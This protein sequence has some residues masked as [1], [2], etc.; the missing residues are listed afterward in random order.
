MNH[1]VRILIAMLLS[2]VFIQQPAVGQ[3]WSAGISAAAGAAAEYY[4]QE[5]ET[6]RLLELERK[7]AA[8]WEAQELRR[9][10]RDEAMRRQAAAE[11]AARAQEEVRRQQQIAEEKRQ[12]EAEQKR[13]AVSTGTGFFV[14][15]GGYLVTN[16]HVID[17]STDY[18]IRDH[19]GRFYKAT[20]VA[21]DS[22]RDLALLKVDISVTPLK[23]L[24]SDTVSKGQRVL[25]V[26]YPQISIQGNES[27][28]TDGIIS[29]FSGIRNDDNWFQIS[30]P[31]QGGNSGGPL[32]TETGGVVGVVVATANFARFY[33]L[34]GNLPQNV[35]Y[36]IKSKVLLEFLNAQNLQNVTTARGKVS[37]DA[38]DASTVLVIAKNGPIDVAYS[39]SPE[40][41]AR[42]EHERTKAA[43]NELRRKREETLVEQKR[44]AQE[45][46]AEKQRSDEA[47]LAVK[48]D[49]AVLKA[50]PDWPEIKV[51][52]IFMA[53]LAVQ[54]KETSDKLISMKATD[55]ISVIR[56]YH[57]ELPKFA[58][59]YLA[60]VQHP[61]PI[62]PATIAP[63]PEVKLPELT[64][65]ATPVARVVGEVLEVFP[66]HGYLVMKVQGAIA[67]DRPVRINT[68][69]NTE[70]TGKVAKTVADRASVLVPSGISV[71]AK[72]DRV[73]Q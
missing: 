57:A 56:Q 27:K 50:F 70:V 6:E 69:R 30:V 31:I 59:G 17:D 38:V 20:V 64:R 12:Q 40:Q 9:Q 32:V 41:T 47:A 63:P 54:K 33:K 26:G 35:N 25:A 62:T 49:T 4:K 11:T 45:R 39:A 53:W 44:L 1:F 72:G 16:H 22:N 5:A 61:Q 10:E 37:I 52:N 24:S 46:L 13:K 71:I 55:V 60:A 19:K 58:N 14:A 3:N 51:S 34:T 15:P 28:V 36:A 42:N 67:F 43:T 2:V 29:S 65:T 23:I 7:R 18:A 48:R 66:D 8:I 73:V 21:R 68:T